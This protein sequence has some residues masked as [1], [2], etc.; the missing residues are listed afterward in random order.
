MP[1]DTPP[2]PAAHPP[3]YDEE[4]PYEGVDLSTFPEWWARNVREFRRHEMRPYRPPRF[5]DGTVTPPVI[6]RLEEALDVPIRIRA[7]DPHE[8][9]DWEVVVDGDVVGTVERTR[10]QGGNSRYGM[11]ADAF[12]TLVREAVRD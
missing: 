5:A 8:D 12:E 2:R 10:T 3:G 9:G 4:S 1:D 7:V 11:T 6:E